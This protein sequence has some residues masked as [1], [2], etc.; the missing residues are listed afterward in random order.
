MF[1]RCVFVL[2]SFYVVVSSLGWLVSA[3]LIGASGG[4]FGVLIACA[5][6]FP[7]MRVIYFIIP[8]QIRTLALLLIVV[9]TL[10]FLRGQNRG[11]ELCHLGGVVTGFLWVTARPYLNARRQRTSR[12]A[13]Q[14]RS[15]D[16]A[17][18]QYE[19][20]RILAKVHEQG[21]HSLTRRE[22]QILHEA[23]E[24]QQRSP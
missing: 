10:G 12:P 4:V 22:R 17:K 15:Q 21:I 2:F 23:T 18:L 6:L 3:D 8:M 7:Q 24:Q 14:R 1:L 11:G 9:G 5:V 16:Q 20:D 13:R 19:V